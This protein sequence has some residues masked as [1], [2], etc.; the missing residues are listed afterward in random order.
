MP[1]S[2]KHLGIS[3]GGTKIHG[4]AGAAREV[5][6]NQCYDPHYYTGISAGAILAIPLALRMFDEIETITCALEPKTFFSQVPVNKKGGISFW[7]GVRAFLGVIGIAKHNSLGHMGNLYKVLRK[8][9]TPK[10]Y[11]E[12][13]NSPDTFIAYVGY[14]DSKSGA[15]K[16]VNLKDPKL[17]YEG[18]IKAIVA[19]A[20]I[21]VFTKP[22]EISEDLGVDGGVRD[23][24]GTPWLLKE[25]KVTRTVSIYS[26][27]EDL[28]GYLNSNWKA[29]NIFD[30]L[31]RTIDI[32][33]I[34]ISKSDEDIE[35]EICK[36]KKIAQKKIFLP[37]I[38]NHVYDTDHKRLND[39]YRAGREEAEKIMNLPW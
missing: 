22:V 37:K 11:L 21:P 31:M 10:K 27:P 15:R 20:S 28:T 7:A 35:D 3:G 38:M 9:I 16:Y 1:D 32:M 14:V 30:V 18:M 4:L 8:V 25:Y 19:S 23:H 13:K 5:L 2:I 24:I 34:E 26:R 39:L 36:R 33:M 29:K 6:E 12:Y 17:G